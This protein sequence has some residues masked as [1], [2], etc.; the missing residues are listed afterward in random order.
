MPQTGVV[1]CIETNLTT[2]DASDKR[3]TI[4]HHIQL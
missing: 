3:A 2:S 4:L 1:K